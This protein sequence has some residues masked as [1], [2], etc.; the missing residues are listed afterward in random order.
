MPHGPHRRQAFIRCVRAPQDIR[1]KPDALVEPTD[2]TRPSPQLADR[3][4]FPLHPFDAEVR[5]LSQFVR[6]GTDNRC[7]AREVDVGSGQGDTGVPGY[8]RHGHAAK[9]CSANSCSAAAR[10]RRVEAE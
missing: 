3:V 2:D 6:Q 8:A 9:R 1:Q 10:M 4:G 7:L 5:R